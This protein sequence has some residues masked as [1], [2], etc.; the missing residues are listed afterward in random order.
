MVERVLGKDEVT[1]SNPVIGSIS[2]IR[3]IEFEAVVLKIKADAK[4]DIKDGSKSEEIRENTTFS[5]TV[6]APTDYSFEGL[7]KYFQGL[8][9]EIAA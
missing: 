9:A 1:G 8:G 6:K 7:Q 3:A 4:V 5:G 2:R